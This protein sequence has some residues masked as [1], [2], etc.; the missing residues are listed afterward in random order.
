[1]SRPDEKREQ[2]KFN[3]PQRPG[4]KSGQQNRPDVRK[5][6]ENSPRRDPSKPQQR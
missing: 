4:E 6:G 3:N 5:E 2:E 1:M